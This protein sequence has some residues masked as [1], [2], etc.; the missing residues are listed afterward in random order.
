MA[1]VP[2]QP[3]LQDE[4][5][6]VEGCI[7]GEA[8]AL[9]QLEERHGLLM[10]AVVLRV[11]D[12][13]RP[14][15]VEEAA[16]VVARVVDHLRRDDAAALRA[17]QPP[18]SLRHYLAVVA[19]QVTESHVQDATPTI[20]LIGA[21]P[22]PA[23]F[24]DDLLVEDPSAKE[25]SAA[26]NRFSPQV[27]AVVRLRL[28]GVDRQGIA[29]TL[30]TPRRNVATILERVAQ[31]LGEMNEGLVEEATDTWR[32]ML[33]GASVADRAYLAL[34]AENEPSIQALQENI[35]EAWDALR[36]R[37]LSR[38]LPRTP[39]CLEAPAIAAFADGS[40]RGAGRARAEGHIATCGRCVDTTARLTMDLRVLGALK[41]ATGQ[42]RDVALAA[43]CLFTGR[44]RA[45]ELLCERAMARGVAIAERLLRVAH[46]GQALMGLRVSRPPP[47]PS[48]VRATGLPSDDDAPL[49]AFEALF[50]GD[51]HGAARAIDDRLAKQNL[52]TRLRLLAHAFGHDLEAARTLATEV[53]GWKRADPGLRDEA[54]AVR[55]LPDTHAFPRATL[56]ERLDDLVPELVRHILRAP[57]A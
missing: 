51:P 53:V 15:H 52:G 24:L 55:A 18:M 25:L 50:Q 3:P 32:V 39:A 26:V 22:A 9:A 23:A 16:S 10:E 45:A 11:L 56:L 54:E 48:Q 1:Q 34:R 5:P 35:A 27:A 42:D 28:R 2:S 8:G 46:V 37:S 57:A 4:A 14:G 30:G 21:L 36:E 19:R 17:W 47:E 31:R 43:A 41:D 13:R 44:Y 49:M 29:A 6:L 40:M 38:L 33:D 20:D 7:Q 12:E